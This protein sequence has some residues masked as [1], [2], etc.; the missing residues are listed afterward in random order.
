M[1]SLARSIGIFASLGLLASVLAIANPVARE[2]ESKPVPHR[3]ELEYLKVVNKAHPP[4]DP[5]LLFLLMGQFSNA[6][7]HRQGIDFLTALLKEYEPKLTNAQKSHYITAIASLRAGYAAEVP[8]WSRIGWVNETVAMLDEAKK[9]G[10]ENAFVARWM[11]GIVRAQLPWF[12]R[13][14]A[15]AEQDLQ[16]V[17]KHAAL[18]PHSGWL[19]EVYF[20][21]GL[22][23]KN[24]GNEVE[25]ASY[26]AKSGLTNW[27]KPVIFT[28]PNAEDANGGHAF[29][30]K[31]IREAV[32]GKVYVLSGY[33]FT[34]YY[35]IV[36][37]DR[38][39]LI[40][41]DAGTRPDSA[42]LAYEALR[43]KVPN[44]PPLTTVFVTHA[45]WD[46][47]G[48]HRYFRQ[49]NPNIKFYG[50]ENF[51][52]EL[53][54]E[55]VAPH[56]LFKRFF[57]KGFNLDDVTSYRPD[58]IVD[59]AS[60]LTIGG[61]R[62]DLL[63]ISGGETED[64]LL[65]HLPQFS[66]MFVGDFIMPYL[67][68][69]FV[70]EG[71]F[72]GLLAAIDIIQKKA[73]SQILHGHEPLTRIF[74]TTAILSELKNHL[75]WLDQQVVAAIKRGDERGTVHQA[76]LIP[77]TLPAGQTAVHLGYFI[78]RENVIN[79]IWDHQVGYWQADLQGMDYLT[80]ADRGSALVDYLGVSE[81]ELATALQKM[82][83]DGK[84]ELAADTYENTKA[85][86]PAG[87]VLEKSGRE[88]YFKLMDKYQEF[89]PFKFI[90][91]SGQ[92]EHVTPQID[93]SKPVAP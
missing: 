42:R 76:N 4:S 71:N 56:T 37:E 33:E 49:V 7:Q 15:A 58:V 22:L 40:S 45:H 77:P 89:S 53:H 70:E 84:H 79:R 9:I 69:P 78:M 74:S 29:A 12:F 6:N 75:Q 32:P 25:A 86:Y 65:V 51:S 62:F 64:A 21:L 90:I 3:P 80:R 73:P 36:S 27:E 87:G 1:K 14:D 28:T 93:V 11:S 30:P 31:L 82:I 47:V 19:R 63:P 60:E 23:R 5:E 48:G 59:K 57:G 16:W 39:H 85:R 20:H 91:Y 41:I 43:A 81:Q 67:G 46:H 38:Q 55:T 83:S 44:L 50:R 88:A 13:E 92:I 61:T 52:H 54:R 8:L 68:A 26:L 17:L 66:T 35:F 34:E 2:K 24:A 18:A 72:P 10:G